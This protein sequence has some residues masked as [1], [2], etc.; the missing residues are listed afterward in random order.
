M[1]A[2]S[3]PSHYDINVYQSLSV[4]AKLGT[5]EKTGA[6]APVSLKRND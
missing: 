4:P 6:K 1:R 5:I 3:R 2:Y